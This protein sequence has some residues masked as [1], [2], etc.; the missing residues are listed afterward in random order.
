MFWP[1]FRW[2]RAKKTNPMLKKLFPFLFKS[3]GSESPAAT[4]NGRAQARTGSVE[5][6]PASA[7]GI[8][9]R[10][11]NHR[12]LRKGSKVYIRQIFDDGQRLRVRG[13]AP[14]G[15]KVTLTVNKRS[16]K[17]FQSEGIPDHLHRHYKAHSMFTDEHEAK[18]K[19]EMYNKRG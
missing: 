14:N 2:I 8:I 5:T 11:R 12:G 10:N 16:L 3:K 17:E 4:T 7:F 18:V 1:V 19:A 13:T 6:Q 9:A 15:K